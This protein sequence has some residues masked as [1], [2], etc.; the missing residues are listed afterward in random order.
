MKGESP[1]AASNSFTVMPA[2]AVTETVRGVITLL[3]VMSC[4]LRMLTMTR[5]SSGSSAFSSWPICASALI[6]PRMSV[7]MASL[8]MRRVI[9]S[10]IQM[11]GF[12]LHTITLR[13]V[14]SMGESWRQ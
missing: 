4:R 8:P 10:D 1:H 12:R 11:K 9:C 2:R 14:A 5:V 3:T 13:V 6:S 7:S